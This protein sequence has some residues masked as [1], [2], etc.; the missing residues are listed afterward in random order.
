M[1]E[2][3]KNIGIVHGACADKRHESWQENNK[4]TKII[5]GDFVKVGIDTG[6]EKCSQ[7][8]LWFK[9]V[10]ISDDRSELLCTVNNSPVLVPDLEWGD[11][12]II[13]RSKIAD[14]IKGE[15]NPNIN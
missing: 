12:M 1:N 4:T 2:E 13:N 5:P 3:I 8:H 11:E 10:K 9:V 7:E 15:Y 14:H 6:D